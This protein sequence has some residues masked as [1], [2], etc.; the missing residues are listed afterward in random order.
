MNNS[1]DMAITSNCVLV[2]TLIMKNLTT[3]LYQ[4]SANWL[5]DKQGQKPIY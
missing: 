4:I 1:L 2:L 3:K 5:L